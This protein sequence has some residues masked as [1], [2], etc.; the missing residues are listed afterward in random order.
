MSVEITLPLEKKQLPSYV[1]SEDNHFVYPGEVIT[2]DSGF[3]KG[4]GTFADNDDRLVHLLSFL[5]E[6]RSL[7]AR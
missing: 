5:H 1:S 3:M 6:G 7:K 2:D 4:H